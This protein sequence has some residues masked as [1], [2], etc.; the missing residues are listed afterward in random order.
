MASTLQRAYDNLRTGQAVAAA[1]L[2]WF[3]L[4]TARGR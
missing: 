2:G 1:L 4:S 3:V